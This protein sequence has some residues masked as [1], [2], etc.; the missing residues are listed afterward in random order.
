MVRARL[1]DELFRFPNL[2]HIF[3]EA[4]CDRRA[5]NTSCLAYSLVPPNTVLGGPFT[6]III[7][8]IIIISECIIFL[9]IELHSSLSLLLFEKKD[10]VDG[11]DHSVAS[12]DSDVDKLGRCIVSTALD[13]EW[14]TILTLF[15]GPDPQGRLST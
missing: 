1:F 14:S 5:P 8:I 11:V 13:A 9:L 4:L 15:F 7:I 3:K 10:I 2:Y 12:L 6:L